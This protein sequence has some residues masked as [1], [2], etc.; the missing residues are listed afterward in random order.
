MA[1]SACKLHI[2]KK[3]L[4]PTRVVPN[5]GKPGPAAWL[6]IEKT[7]PGPLK[8]RN[9]QHNPPGR[10]TA[11]NNLPGGCVGPIPAQARW[12]LQAIMTFQPFRGAPGRRRLT[13]RPKLAGA[14]LAPA[15]HGAAPGRVPADAARSRPPAPGPRVEDSPSR[16]DVLRSPTWLARRGRGQSSESD[17]SRRLRPRSR[18]LLSSGSGAAA[19]R[20]LALAALR[21]V[22]GND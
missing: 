1:P 22:P 17:G 12:W 15:I 20:L 10:Q 21:L 18:R 7:A 2:G 8:S 3:L 5:V 4:F 14:I 19:D 13:R 11:L 16:R 6:I 9:P